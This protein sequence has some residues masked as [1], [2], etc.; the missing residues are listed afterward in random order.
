M[1]QVASTAISAGGGSLA[2]TAVT[3]YGNTATSHGGAIFNGN[4]N[5]TLTDS[6]LWGDSGGEI[7]NYGASSSTVSYSDIQGGYAGSGNL[8]TDP[9]LAPLGDY[10]GGLQ[11]MALLP[12]SPAIGATSSNCHAQDER[13]VTRSTPTCDLGAFESTG[14]T[15]AKSGGD[16]QATL[17]RTAFSRPLVVTVTANNPI[18][19]VNGGVITFI[20]PA[21]G[22]SAILASNPVMIVGGKASITAVA[23]GVAGG[24]YIISATAPG[25]EARV[26]FNLMNRQ[27]RVFLPVLRK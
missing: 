15:L 17:I 6:I 4:N 5:L 13:G 11:T 12:S 16:N 10:G 25:V 19:P 26:I 23:N 3:F 1:A 20:V 24:P 8:N 27:I 2:A 9:L 22:P 21:T 14:F 18:E 7:Y